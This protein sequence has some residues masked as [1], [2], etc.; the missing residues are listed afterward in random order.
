MR[1]EAHQLQHIK[2]P[3]EAWHWYALASL[4]CHIFVIAVVVF[5]PFSSVSMPEFSDRNVIEVDLASVPPQVNTPL[6]PK[7]SVDKGQSEPSQ[8]K[9]P[10]DDAFASEET[11]AGP[12]KPKKSGPSVKKA[13]KKNFDPSD[14]QV[15]KPEKPGPKIK[16]AMKDKTI[17]TAAV[18]KSVVERMKEESGDSRPWSVKERID[19][20][21]S[22]V[23]GQD[24]RLKDRT[25]AHLKGGARGRPTDMTQI[26]VYQAEVAVRLKNNWVFSEKLAG[27]TQGL[28][29]RLLIEILPD[30]SITDVM[31]EKRSGNK[32][33]DQSAYKTVMKCDPL[34]PLPEGYK[35]Y[36]LMVGF[37]PSGLKRQ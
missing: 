20:L 10:A 21:K 35:K 30:G 5:F 13:R 14:Y 6:P 31:Y 27:Q 8:P 23:P 18:H 17:R 36:H 34:P 9:E 22:E 19:E 15:K 16:S 26:Q 3:E 32:Y 29:S 37:T 12:E 1:S 11:A 25:T 7:S 2:S 28:E 33:L 24:R 4:A